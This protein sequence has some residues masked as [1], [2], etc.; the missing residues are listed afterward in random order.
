MCKYTG[1]RV[2]NMHRTSK[3]AKMQPSEDKDYE[4][5]NAE[6]LSSGIT[7][8][9]LHMLQRFC[10]SIT[11]FQLQPE[12]FRAVMLLLHLNELE[13]ALTYFYYEKT[14]T[15]VK[16]YNCDQ[17]LLLCAYHA[18]LYLNSKF[19]LYERAVEETFPDF[20]QVYREF[21]NIHCKQD[22]VDPMSFNSCFLHLR[23]A[24]SDPSH[25]VFDLNHQADLLI[26]EESS[27]EAKDSPFEVLCNWKTALPGMDTQT[28]STSS[29]EAPQEPSKP[30]R[31][32]EPLSAAMEAP[33]EP[34]KP[35][36]EE[37]PL[38]AAMEAPDDLSLSHGGSIFSNLQLARSQS[39]FASIPQDPS[40]P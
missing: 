17:L 38:S 26:T 34:S 20:R 13:L 6:Y 10:D 5:L 16:A 11:D 39:L 36:R 12:A 35:Y 15:R 25:L 4:T 29:L 2:T 3:I 33:Q 18:K 24:P 30:H 27:A 23:K 19:R 9:L 32:E 8:P 7:Q 1:I 21:A 14:H 40:N 28:E 31:E 22:A 37:E